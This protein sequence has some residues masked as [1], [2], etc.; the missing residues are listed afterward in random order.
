MNKISKSVY[1]LAE[2]Y[3]KAGLEFSFD[4]KKMIKELTENSYKNNAIENL[5]NVFDEEESV[6]DISMEDCEI[7]TYVRID[8][9]NNEF[10]DE[11]DYKEYIEQKVSD[12]FENYTIIEDEDED[13][14]EIF[15]LITGEGEIYDTFYSKEDAIDELEVLKE[16][17]IDEFAYWDDLEYQYDEIYYNYVYQPSCGVDIDSAQNA[18]LGVLEFD[19]EQYLFLRGCG[20]DMSYQFVKY[21]AYAEKA[22][23]MKYV[24]KLDWTKQNSCKEE[25][26]NILE[27]LGVDTSRLSNL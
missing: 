1:A 21:Y 16:D 27:C 22:L 19:D 12:K 11:E 4:S 13:G 7:L 18:G 23:P 9:E 10:R 2:V 14:E 20:M 15:N 26:K 17:F 24:D 5:V 3:R 6:I 8:D 25:F